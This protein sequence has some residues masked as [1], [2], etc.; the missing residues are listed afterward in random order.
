MIQHLRTDARH[1]LGLFLPCLIETRQDLPKGWHVV[2][3][4]G[5]EVRAGVERLEVRC[6]EYRHRPTTRTR[7]RLRGCHVD[8]IQVRAL[9]AVDLDTDVMLVHETRRFR[10]F[11]GFVGHD[12]TPMAGRVSDAQKNGL[13]LGTCLL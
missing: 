10:V 8:A 4:Y 3:S 12:V 13:I 9:F 6:E 2:P 5:W 7:K 1:L 11:E